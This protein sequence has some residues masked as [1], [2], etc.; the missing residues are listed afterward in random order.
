MLVPLV[1]MAISG[2]AL[3]IGGSFG[4]ALW[5]RRWL[6]ADL[7]TSDAAHVFVGMNEVKGTVAPAGNPIV[8][9]YTAIQCVWYRSLLEREEKSGDNKSWKTV[10]DV[11]SEA[12]FWIQ[13]RSGHV[14]VRPK[15]ASVYAREKVRDEHGGR[16]PR[17]N[18]MSVL[19]GGG[20][21]PGFLAGLFTGSQRYRTTEWVLRPDEAVYLLG[22]ASLRTDTIALE[23]SPYHPS[24]GAKQGSLFISSGDESKAA[25][26]T[27]WQGLGLLLLAFVGAVTLPLEWQFFLDT[28]ETSD[29]AL[30]QPATG[31][32]LFDAAKGG[33]TLVVIA[34]LVALPVVTVVRIYNRLI[35]VR[36]RAEAAWSLV[37]VHLRRRHDLIPQ[38]VTVVQ[39]AAA[40]EHDV[41][42]AVGRG[43]G[44]RRAAAVARPA[45]PRD[46]PARRRGRRGRPVLQPPAPR[47]RRGVPGAARRRQLR[48]ARR[49]DH[50]QRGRR[51]LR[52]D[53]L[54]RRRHRHGGPPPPV[55]RRAA[56]PARHHAHD[57]PLRGRPARGPPRHGGGA[58]PSDAPAGDL[59]RRHLQ[60]RDPVGRRAPCSRP[61]S[62]SW[63][64]RSRSRSCCSARRP[65]TDRGLSSDGARAR[66]DGL[67]RLKAVALWAMLLHHLLAWSVGDARDL[68]GDGEVAVTDLAAP[69]FAMAAGAGA[70][71]VGTRLRRHAGAG[72]AKALGRWAVIAGWGV[73]LG[74]RGDHAVDTVGVLETLALVGVVVTLLARWA[75]PTA[76]AWAAI[77]AGLTVTSTPV[78]EA[79][80]DAGGWWHAAFGLRFPWVSYL[81][82]AAAGAAV[83]TA[84]GDRERLGRLVP[85]AAGATLLLA[86]LGLLHV[87]VWPLDRYPSG[88]SFIVPGVVAALVTWAVVAA[89]PASSL[90]RGMQRAG[91]R[92]LL[93]YVGPPRGPG[94]PRRRRLVPGPRGTGLDGGGGRPHGRHRRRV[95]APVACSEPDP[96]P[97]CSG[98]RAERHRDVGGIE[99]VA[100]HVGHELDVAGRDVEAHPPLA[101]Q[102]GD[103]RV[104]DGSAGLEVQRRRRRF[105]LA[106]REHREVA[107][108]RRGHRHHGQD[109]RLGVGRAR[110]C[111]ARRSGRGGWWR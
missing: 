82:M 72:T 75:A 77:A 55:P 52:P 95:S 96:Y 73:L 4:W 79:A 88:P 36:N 29:A 33:M 108:G 63:P 21:E 76:V 7:P 3:V 40:H 23:F 9:P 11:S 86:V 17:Y 6:I 10:E 56:G 28:R 25:R 67:D 22:S 83:A 54:Q 47:R 104:G 1:F 45:G 60:D 12:P 89:L 50:H 102:G 110:P 59:D 101:A 38:L 26:R 35:E 97:S 31:Q 34:F 92:T 19:T 80:A 48:P 90:T 70:A 32:E 43:A 74:V 20:D 27:F 2:A 42:E 62:A 58:E 53:L 105:G 68:L 100:R 8:A 93:V 91:Q 44:R 69:A 85:A 109:H 37:D 78:I 103:H 99:E 71:I 39:A 87:G 18:S 94:R 13:D 57:G 98:R 30:S 51:R 5:R 66:F 46:P 81:A 64:A 111:S 65:S 15:G 49:A 41:Q 16:P 14:L 106:G 84:L 107:V 24:S 61:S